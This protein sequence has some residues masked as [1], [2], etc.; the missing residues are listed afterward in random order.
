MCLSLGATFFQVLGAV[1]KKSFMALFMD[2][3]QLPQGYR[4][5]TRR[6]FTFSQKFLV[7]I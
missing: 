3:V 1:L 4:A 7:L 6:Q 2:G 5:T